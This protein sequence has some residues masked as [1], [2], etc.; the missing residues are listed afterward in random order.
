MILHIPRCYTENSGRSSIPSKLVC[1]KTDH[2]TA[3]TLSDV[4]ARIVELSHTRYLIFLQPGKQ[5]VNKQPGLQILSLNAHRFRSK[6]NQRKIVIFSY[7]SFLAFVL[8]DQN[9][10]LIET[11][12]LST[13]NICFDCLIDLIHDVPSTIFQL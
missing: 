7:L 9:N 8:G 3:Y 4:F 5:I 12:F 1:I 11:V 13:H 10:R 2:L 6:K